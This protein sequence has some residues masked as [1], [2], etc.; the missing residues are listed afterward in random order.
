[1]SVIAEFSLAPERFPLGAAIEANPDLRITFGTSVPL[2]ERY[3]PYLWVTT[4]NVDSFERLARADEHVDDLV[5]ID[6]IGGQALYRIDWSKREHELVHAIQEA[7]AEILEATSETVWNFRV[8]FFDHTRLAQFGNACREDQ[9]PIQI[10]HVYQLTESAIPEPKSS[11]TPAQLKAITLAF[12][13]GYYSI[14]RKVTAKDLG[15]ELGISDSAVTERLRRAMRN[16]IQSSGLVG[17]MSQ[18]S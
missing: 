3:I 6:E 1:M 18:A 12:E 9:I 13:R 15:E 2:G 10:N 17:A 11:L 14:P 16:L 5:Q 8:L 7:K 4:Q